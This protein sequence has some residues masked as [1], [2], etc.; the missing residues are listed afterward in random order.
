MDPNDASNKPDFDATRRADEAVRASYEAV[1]Y[2]SGAHYQTHPALLAV[3][4]WLHGLETQDI[5][6]CRVLELGCA[7]GGNLLPMA[8]QLPQSEFLGIDISASGIAVGNEMIDRLGLDNVR[9]EERSLLD[10][11]PDFGQFDYIIVHGLFSWVPPP[12]R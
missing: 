4:A 1:P 12:V 2:P 8:S 7:D 5:E 6:N 11:G 9:L 3:L 10:I